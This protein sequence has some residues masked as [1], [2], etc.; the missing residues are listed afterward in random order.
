MSNWPTLV[1]NLIGYIRPNWCMPKPDGY[2][3]KAMQYIMVSPRQICA[4]LGQDCKSQSC[5]IHLEPV[6][7]ATQ[8]TSKIAD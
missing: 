1:S 4:K 3:S 7:T 8:T 2:S 6:E 5:R